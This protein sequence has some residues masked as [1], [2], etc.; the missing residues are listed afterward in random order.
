LNQKNREQDINIFRPTNLRELLSYIYL[1]P[2]A[3]LVAG[4]IDFMHGDKTKSADF[5]LPEKLV[6]LTTVTE[7]KKINKTMRYLDLGSGLTLSRILSIRYHVVPLLLHT[8][9]KAISGPSIRNLATLGGNICLA[10]PYSN[11]L[12]ALCVLDAH[13]EIRSYTS[14][15]WEPVSTFMMGTATKQIKP[16][17]ARE[18]LVARIQPTSGQIRPTLARDEIVARVRI[19][20]NN[21]NVQVFHKI[22][23]N[24]NS[25]QAAV[26]FCGLAQITKGVIDDFRFAF[27]AINRVVYRNRHLEKPF[28]GRKVPLQQRDVE[29]LKKALEESLSEGC[30]Q[31]MEDE[32]ATCEYRK[33]TALKLIESFLKSLKP[34]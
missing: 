22:G 17:F 4:G 34:S 12:P 9:L 26:I 8:A 21:W 6:D 7:L 32:V 15:R 33:S 13:L 27:G 23:S 28:I 24:H 20:L 2:E 11:T 16:S 10:S 31:P 25:S 29:M 14:F 18:E 19:P 5:S 30:L 1:N 3:S